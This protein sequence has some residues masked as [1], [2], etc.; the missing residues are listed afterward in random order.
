MRV[1]QTLPTGAAH[2]APSLL[3]AEPATV[4]ISVDRPHVGMGRTVVLTAQASR[5][6]H[7][8]AAGIQL[9]PYVNGRRWGPHET[10]DASGRAVFHLPLPTV[11]PAR[12]QVQARTVPGPPD[13]WWIWAGTPQEHQT[14]WLQR[15]SRSPSRRPAN[16]GWP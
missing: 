14:I 10:A 2:A 11:G 1:A 16:Y 13:D 12:I 8:P 7:Q 4:K 6:D 5:P 9:L 3:S 15:S